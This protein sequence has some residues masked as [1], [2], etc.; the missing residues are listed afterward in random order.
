MAMMKIK[1]VDGMER[2]WGNF[3]LGIQV[4]EEMTF[5]LRAK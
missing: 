4:S 3:R 5:T 2:H 1:Q